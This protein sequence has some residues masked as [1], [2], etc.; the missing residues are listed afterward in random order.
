MFPPGLEVWS[1]LLGA[2]MFI[3]YRQQTFR[4]S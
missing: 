2:K 4:P 3:Q 1:V